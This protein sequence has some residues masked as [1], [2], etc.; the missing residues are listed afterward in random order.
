MKQTQS[1]NILITEKTLT[2]WKQTDI[3]ISQ[4][5]SVGLLFPMH[6]KLDELFSLY[7]NSV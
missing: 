6:T 3:D 7:M 1:H 4:W 2:L 5:L